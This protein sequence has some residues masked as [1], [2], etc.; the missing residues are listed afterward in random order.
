MRV[1]FRLD[2]NAHVGQGHLMRSAVLA[3]ALAR[4]GHGVSV[5]ARPLA[6]ALQAQLSG[7]QLAP[8]AEHSDG[9]SIGWWSTTT[10]WTP[11]GKA[12]PA[13]TPSTSW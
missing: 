8:V 5:L 7:C 6:P 2:A 12:R 10:G 9:R 11:N 4:R 3:R 1:A 13:S